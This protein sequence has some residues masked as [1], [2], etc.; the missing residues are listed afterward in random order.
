M[1]PVRALSS[2]P[3]RQYQHPPTI[4]V[5][6]TRQTR[7]LRSVSRRMHAPPPSSAAHCLPR[8]LRQSH[9]HM[10]DASRSLLSAC[11]AVWHGPRA[12]RCYNTTTERDRHRLLSHQCV[13]ADV[14]RPRAAQMPMMCQATGVLARSILTRP[15]TSSHQ[16]PTFYPVCLCKTHC[17][18]HSKCLAAPRHRQ[19]GCLLAKQ[20]RRA[21]KAVVRHL[22]GS[23]TFDPCT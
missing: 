23:K 20:G 21:S 4:C 3:R 22:Q 11:D 12:H 1:S 14:A 10:L 18:L 13:S 2:A 19:A 8:C 6:G 17:A 15:T 5:R 7:G 16:S 9:R